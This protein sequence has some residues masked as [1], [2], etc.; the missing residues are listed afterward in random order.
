M[1]KT[2]C[3]FEG[4]TNPV[5]NGGLCGGHH[6]HRALGRS[7]KPLTP[8]ASPHRGAECDI[9]DCPKPRQARGFCSA[10]YAK[11]RKYGDPL[12]SAKFM[13]EDACSVEGCERPAAALS[14]CSMHRRRML[15]NGDPLVALR[16]RGILRDELG[17]KMCVR[18]REWCDLSLFGLNKRNV[19]G[20][21]SYCKPC[22]QTYQRKRK[23][24]LTAEA[25]DALLEKQ[26]G[27]CAVCLTTNPGPKDW[28]V[29]HDHSCCPHLR[30]TAV[31][32]GKCV[33][34]LLCHSCN[35]SMGGMKDD[36]VRLR[37]AADYL[38]AYSRQAVT[39]GVA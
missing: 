29:D 10:H 36:P 1:A 5:S 11:F 9:E 22:A 31:S 8:R 16:R 6:Y 26:G 13:Y 3:S 37:A 15:N 30:G 39:R 18:C 14:L 2:I 17:R 35:T 27:R 7:L 21:G 19:D 20:L 4:C 12:A 32:C 33:R 25:F 24:G 28:H 38:E 23:F 34:G